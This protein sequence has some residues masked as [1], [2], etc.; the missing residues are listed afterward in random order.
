MKIISN[1]RKRIVKFFMSP[2]RYAKFIGV[3]IGTNNFIPDKNCW[4]SEPYLITIGS[5]CQITTG[6]RI[7]T[8]GGGNVVRN[9]LPNFDVFGRVTIGDWVYIGTNSLIMP[10]VTIGDGALI[11]A[12]SVVTK[13]VPPKVVVDGNPARIISTIEK[14]IK[15][16]ERFNLNSKKMSEDEKARFL[17]SLSEEKFITKKKMIF[18]DNFNMK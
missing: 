3:K 18:P 10:G 11:A 9:V 15:Q 5:N 13:S 2:E 16:N 7:F 4:S 14:Y 12:G 1:I 17:I 8:H 6:V